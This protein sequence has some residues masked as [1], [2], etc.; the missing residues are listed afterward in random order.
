VIHLT[1]TC[2]P[3]PRAESLYL[4]RHEFYTSLEV[5]AR[6]QV[7]INADLRLAVF[8]LISSFSSASL[9]EAIDKYDAEIVKR[10]S[11]EVGTSV[12][13]AI[14]LTHQKAMEAPVLAQGYAKS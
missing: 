9:K 13:S 6:S 5:H 12:K 14:F 4:G 10:G 2:R 11:D 7:S 3:R 1:I 8:N